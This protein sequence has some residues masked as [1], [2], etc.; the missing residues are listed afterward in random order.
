MERVLRQRLAPERLQPYIVAAGSPRAAIRLYQWNVEVSGASYEALHVVEVVLRNSLHDQLS[1]LHAKRNGVGSWLDS[2]FAELTD[3]ARADIVTARQRARE[4]LARKQSPPARGAAL[5]AIKPT[6]GDVVAQ[7]GFGFWRYLLATRYT[8]T[9]WLDALR[10]AF[11]HLTPQAVSHVEGP[12]QRL[13]LLRNRI[14]HLE[15]VFG[16]NLALSLQDM[17]TLL[18]YACPR[19]QAWFGA[20]RAPRLKAA[21]AARPAP[22]R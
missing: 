4:G 10:H 9:L 8:H 15:P 7:L 12:V 1:L 22:K 14:A 19:T 18:G 2:P 11:P 16:S 5:R 13:H 21:L 20:T 17:T 6:D 3:R